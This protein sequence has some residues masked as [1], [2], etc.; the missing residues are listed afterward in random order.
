MRQT[1]GLAAIQT[2]HRILIVRKQGEWPSRKMLLRLCQRE[3]CGLK[4]QFVAAGERYG[5]CADPWFV[6]RFV[7]QNRGQS[8]VPFLAGIAEDEQFPDM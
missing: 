2:S 6:I 8:T 5:A 4:F 1:I 3:E 7:E